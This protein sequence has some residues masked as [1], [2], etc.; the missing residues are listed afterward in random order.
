MVEGTVFIGLMIVALTEVVKRLVPQVTGLVTIG[1]SI[2]VG[3]VVAL[4]DTAIGVTDLT[5]AEGIMAGLA[6]S[7]TVSVARAIS[8]TA[9]PKDG[10]RR[11]I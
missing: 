3:I 8:S 4:V 5:I 2:L 11:H 10:E 7:G 9:P 1:V 6:A